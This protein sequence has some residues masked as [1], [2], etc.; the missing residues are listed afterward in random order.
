VAEALLS[1]DFFLIFGAAIQ[2]GSVRVGTN[3]AFTPYFLNRLSNAAR[4]SFA[5]RGACVTPF[6][7]ALPTAPEGSASRATVTR[8]EKNSHVLA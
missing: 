2:S 5:L 6:S 4:A 1:L 7:P 3:P 8:G